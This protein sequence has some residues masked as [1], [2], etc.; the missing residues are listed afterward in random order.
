MIASSRTIPSISAPMCSIPSLWTMVFGISSSVRRRRTGI[1]PRRRL[2]RRPCWAVHF[3]RRFACSFASFWSITATSPLS[4]AQAQS[5]RTASA[6]PLPGNTNPFSAAITVHRK[7][8]CTR[9]NPPSAPSTQAPSVSRRWI[10]GSGAGSNI[11][12]SRWESLSSGFPALIMRAFSCRVQRASAIPQVPT[13][14]GWIIP[15]RACSAW[16]AASE[17][18]RWIAVRAPIR[19][20][21]R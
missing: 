6:T 21:S 1:S 13:A 9:L 11:W 16:C 4:C 8:A 12:M 14:S 15:R 19:V 10:T 5:S 20:W 2:S 7:N 17:L 18:P 3:L